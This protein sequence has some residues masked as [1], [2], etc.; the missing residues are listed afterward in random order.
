[1]PKSW[2]ISLPGSYGCCAYVKWPPQGAHLCCV[3]EMYSSDASS[4]QVDIQLPNDLS[5]SSKDVRLEVFVQQIGRRIDDEYYVG[6]LTTL[7]DRFC[8]KLNEKQ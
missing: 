4:A 1:M 7:N 8:H 3:S 5:D 2:R 6:L